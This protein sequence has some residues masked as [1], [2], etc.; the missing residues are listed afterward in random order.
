MGRALLA[1][2]VVVRMTGKDGSVTN[3]ESHLVGRLG[4]DGRLVKVA[5]V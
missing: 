2:R 4:D 3:G 5:E 1:V